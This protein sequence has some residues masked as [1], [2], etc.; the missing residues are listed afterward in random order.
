MEQDPQYSAVFTEVR[1]QVF[2]QLHEEAWRRAM[3]GDLEPIIYNGVQCGTVR[4]KSDRLLRFLL[5]LPA[6]LA[7]RIQEGRARVAKLRQERAEE[8]RKSTSGRAS[9]NTESIN[10]SIVEA[11]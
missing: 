5:Q 9:L 1:Q 11:A 8:E 7:E 6:D 10:R 3:E 4:R 2:E